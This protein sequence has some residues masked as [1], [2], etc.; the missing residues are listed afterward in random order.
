MGKLWKK[1]GWIPT[2]VLGSAI[3]ALGFSLFLMPNDMNPGGISGLAQVLVEVLGFGSV[4][5]I[6][7]LINLPLFLMGG[8]KIG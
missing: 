3:F 6:A 2:T 7:I 8:V 5:T 4:G 1:Y